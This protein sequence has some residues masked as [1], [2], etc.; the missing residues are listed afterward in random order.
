[1]SSFQ[2]TL[3]PLAH[4]QPVE[5]DGVI[6]KNLFLSVPR[7]SQI[8]GEPFLMRVKF[9]MSLLA[10]YDK[11]PFHHSVHLYGPSLEFDYQ[12]FGIRFRREN[13]TVI[14]YNMTNINISHALTIETWIKF[15]SDGSKLA[16][17]DWFTI[18]CKGYVWSNAAYCLL[19]AANSTNKS[20][21]FCL[22][23]TKVVTT[24]TYFRNGLWNHIVATYDGSSAKIY[25]NG[26]L[27]STAYFTK[28]IKDNDAPLYIGWEPG[29]IYPLNGSIN[30][31][32]IYAEA[33]N[34][35][36]VRLAYED[37]LSLSEKWILLDLNFR[38]LCYKLQ[39]SRD[40]I[41]YQDVFC[42]RLELPFIMWQ[43]DQPGRYF[44]RIV[45]L[46][47]TNQTSIS[48]H[49][50]TI[51]VDVLQRSLPAEATFINTIFIL[52]ILLS[53]LLILSWRKLRKI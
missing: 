8:A 33:L 19:F 18:V 46:S 17:R 12:R 15:S 13:D 7:T 50:N 52:S 40:G 11:S 20:V 9:N 41:N 34:E 43:E 37:K 16:G 27:A 4:A 14:V 32:R 28:V 36:E 45:L 22:D 48:L 38:D 1:L 30:L 53:A 3:I 39:K 35:T 47:C 51:V 25:I 44:Y 29:N 31:V 21:S 24:N 26:R 23:G 49:S 10:L 6:V 5:I 42:Q 2:Y